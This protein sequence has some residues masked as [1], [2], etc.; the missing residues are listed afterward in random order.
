MNMH[1][2]KLIVTV[3]IITFL[4]LLIPLIMIIVSSF[5]TDSIIKFPITGFTFDWYVKVFKSRTFMAGLK[6]SITLAF[7]ASLIGIIIALPTSYALSKRKT[8]IS[9][10]LL[11]YFLSP[12]LIPGIVMGYVLFHALV[13]TLKLSIPVSLLV[14]HLLIVLPFS[15]RLLAASFDTMDDSIEEAALTLGCSPL[16]SF[17]KV[18]LPNL[19]SPLVVA[20]LM[21][22]IN[23]FNNLPVS[24]Y[25]KGPGVTTLPL[26]LMNHL[27]FNFDPTISAISVLLMIV[28]FG[29]MIFVDKTAGIASIAK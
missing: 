19:V 5:G 20:M 26:A 17:F 7:A 3:T 22:F 10:K 12:N 27:E 2:S 15:I 11:S 23:S 25:L 16:M 9:K 21:S 29:L 28:T 18:V 14:G 24:M 6:T 13:L 8:K 4:F 1:K